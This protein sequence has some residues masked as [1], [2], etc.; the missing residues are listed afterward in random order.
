M[1]KCKNASRWHIDYKKNYMAEFQMEYTSRCV[2]HD[3]LQ[4][5]L[6]PFKQKSF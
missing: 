6:K 2:Q 3:E 1:S 4:F 5:Y